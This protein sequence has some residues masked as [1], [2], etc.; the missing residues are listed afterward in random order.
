M[1]KNG[2]FSKPFSV[3]CFIIITVVIIIY[4]SIINVSILADLH[5]WKPSFSKKRRSWV[6][7]RNQTPRREVT[8]M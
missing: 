2:R 1:K 5:F 6:S 8:L 4:T 7:D 3:V